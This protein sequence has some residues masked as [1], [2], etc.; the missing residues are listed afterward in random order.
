MALAGA[1]A[2]AATAF[3]APVSPNVK[4]PEVR[5]LRQQPAAG[6]APS[7]TGP[8]LKALKKFG[9]RGISE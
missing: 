1:G 2:Y 4:Q 5:H 6:E 8:G 9:S 7:A 3:L